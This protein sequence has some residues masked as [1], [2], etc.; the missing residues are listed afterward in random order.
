[1]RRLPDALFGRARQY[2][3]GEIEPV[4][5]ADAATVVLLR[6]HPREGL[7]VY[8]LRRARSMSF[9]AGMHAFPGGGVDPR[10]ADRAIGWSGPSPAAWADTFTVDEPLAR[11]LVCAAV[12]ET[13]E[14]TGVLLAG[15][16]PEM[17]VADTRGP[18][19]SADRAGLVD[20]SL[21]F[22]D[23]LHR[24]GLVLRSDLLRAW[25]HWVT[26][27]FEPRRYD[28][29][30]FVAA[31]PRGQQARD[32]GG[33]SDQAAWVRPAE[34]FAAHRRGEMAMMLPT[35][36]TLSELAEFGSVTQ[37]LARPRTPRLRMPA[38]RVEGD[39]GEGSGEGSGEGTA[40][41]VLPDT[42]EDPGGPLDPALDPALDPPAGP[43][44]TG[45]T[46]VETAARATRAEEEAMAGRIDGS[47]SPRAR[48]V[49]APNPSP[50][51]LDGTNTWLLAEP[52][53]RRAVVVDPGPDDEGHLAR[54]VASARERDLRVALVLL[55]HAHPDHSAGA[56]RLAELTG[57]PVR[58]LDPAHQ[59]GD[60][61]LVEG[62]VVALDGLEI[63]VLETPGHSDDSLSFLVPADG[64]LLTGDT[65]LGRGT[66]MVSGS[67]GLGD[68]LDSLRRLHDLAASHP[69]G[70]LLP[71]HG[72]ILADP[73]AALDA[74]LAHRRERLEQVEAALAAGA[75]GPAEVVRHVYADLD[76]ALWPAAEESVRA[77]LD[78]LGRRGAPGTPGAPG[79]PGAPG[80]PGTLP[81]EGE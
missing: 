11:A 15:A 47:G 17:V 63:R 36:V 70:S 77:Q 74:Y 66:A 81:A 16:G 49:L 2:V 28:T 26:P 19:W 78:Y 51:T 43:A 42:V 64:V 52:A 73:V 14:E 61:G 69:V 21:A 54:V 79:A 40:Y 10:D 50:M 8:L 6:D 76:P 9:A 67:G 80:T 30:F 65:V 20:R 55:T 35:A 18:G 56:R 27:E 5:P 45:A 22:V 24:R 68:Y 39:A 31:L 53:G 13:F 25:A 37:V 33:E 71:G 3:N 60:E 12:R 44:G 46:I 75:R 23:L 62:E 72:P 41:L 58:A 7:Q 59:L 48:C 57:A 1:M 32:L 4:R 34:A 29:R 38:V